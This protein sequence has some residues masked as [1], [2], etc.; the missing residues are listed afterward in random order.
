MFY[1]DHEPPHFH[2]IYGERRAIVGIGPVE[3][4]AG[5]LPPR[6]ASLVHDWARLHTEELLD[7]W[8]RAREHMGLVRIA[9]LE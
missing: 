7:N 2:A 9:P 8:R 1:N 4:L 5:S 3:V 6:A